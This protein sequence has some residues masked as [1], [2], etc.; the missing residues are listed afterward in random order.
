MTMGK[1]IPM[2][3][4]KKVTRGV[5]FWLAMQTAL[6]GSL[7]TFASAATSY[8]RMTR[9]GVADLVANGPHAG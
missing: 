2:L 5:A 6:A 7:A 9:M 8:C 1:A 4:V 3:H